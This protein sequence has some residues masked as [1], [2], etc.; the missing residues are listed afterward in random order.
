[1]FLNWLTA[2][3]SKV[4]AALRMDAS[5]FRAAG[6]EEQFRSILKAWLES[7]PV[8]GIRW[9]YRLVLD[10]IAW[11]RD[12]EPRPVFVSLKSEAGK[13]EMF[14]FLAG[15]GIGIFAVYVPGHVISFKV[16]MI[17][18]PVSLALVV[19]LFFLFDLGIRDFQE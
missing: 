9:E 18:C 17:A 19:L 1:M 7:L 3:S 14:K 13:C 4:K 10:E 16:F 6:A 2:H 11:W 15:L 5:T 8:P 12:F